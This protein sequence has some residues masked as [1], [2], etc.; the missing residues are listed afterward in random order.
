MPGDERRVVGS[1]DPPVVPPNTTLM[2]RF[3]VPRAGQWAIF[4]NGGELIGQFD[5]KGRRGDLPMGIDVAVDGS[6]SWW[7]RENCP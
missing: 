5:V 6:E 7:C 3:L 2:A 4:A 1:V